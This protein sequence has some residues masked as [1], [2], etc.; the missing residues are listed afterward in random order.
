MRSA[1]EKTQREFQRERSAIR[2]SLAIAAAMLAGKWAA[3]AITG[4]AAILSDAGESVIH[5]AAVGFAALSI[6]LSHRPADRRFRYG[7]ERISFFSAGFEGALIML[8]AVLIIWAAV[9][10]WMRGL[11]LHQ[12]G[13]GAMIIFVAAAV[14]AGLG[15]YLIRVGRRTQSLILE[16]NGKHVLTDSWTSLGVVGG[17]LLVMV[18]G[19]KP[20]DPL[21]AVAAALNILWAGGRL[22]EKSIGGLMDYA[23]PKTAELLRSRL[24]DF[25]RREKLQYHGLRFRDTGMRLMVDVH[26]LFPY[27]TLLGSA[28]AAATRLEEELPVALG[29]EVEVVTH[30]EAVEDHGS[31]HSK[32]HWL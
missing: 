8:A 7:Y 31:V 4:S 16:A 17:V 15:W 24:D 21:V 5:L 13:S 12:L 22:M 3:Y 14:N 10:K 23:D 18:T 30:L 28:H 32:A 9:N 20:F 29:R 26:L 2:L 6:R 19:W 25:C 27:G 11:E 1:P